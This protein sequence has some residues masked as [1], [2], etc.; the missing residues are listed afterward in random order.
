MSL[1][2]KKFQSTIESTSLQDPS[3]QLSSLFL[4]KTT[5]F[6][7]LFE[8]VAN[9]TFLTL[10]MNCFQTFQL[11]SFTS[12]LIAAIHKYSCFAIL[13]D[14][15]KYNTCIRFSRDKQESLSS[16]F[17]LFIENTNTAYRKDRLVSL[18]LFICRTFA[19]TFLF[20]HLLL[21]VTS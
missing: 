12:L 4:F 11:P 1:C 16:F 3:K 14:L 10:Y 2:G 5:S 15:K 8:H 9:K 19:F 20:S 6:Q 7:I 17:F 18:H 13:I 21:K